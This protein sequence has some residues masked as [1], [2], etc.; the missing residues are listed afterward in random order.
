MS[1]SGP[2][3]IIVLGAG[4]I[5]APVGALLHEC[6]VPVVLVARGEHGRALRV[7]GLDLRLPNGSRTLPT[8]SVATLAE[9]Q[10]APND[11]VIVSVMSQDTPKAVADLSPQATVLSL[12][13]GSSAPDFLAARGH[14][15]LAGVAYVPAERRAPGV[16]VLPG[17]PQP[18][19]LLLG[20]W[21]PAP[22]PVH[23]IEWLIERLRG[24]GFRAEHEPTLAPWAR[25]KL[26]ENIAGIAVA[27]C[28]DPPDDVAD[29]AR[30]EARAVWKAAGLAYVTSKDL[31]ERM[32]ELRVVPVDGQKRVGGSTRHALQRRQP[33]E[34]RS[35]HQPIIDLGILHGV[36]TPVNCGLVRLA[37]EAVASSW[38]PGSLSADALRAA[39]GL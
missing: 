28:D 11:L 13:N 25:G 5:G 19:T 35:L 17:T 20:A 3:R 9:A 1:A 31:L 10:P 36:P 22:S 12:Q 14:T 32:G 26:L 16:V 39:V 23:W 38:R 30:D 21:P 24:V 7:A 8:P 27:L 34:T 37:E 29:A 33:L 4:A 15:L 18:G 6:G 2:A